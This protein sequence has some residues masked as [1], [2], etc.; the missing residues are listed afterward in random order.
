[1]KIKFLLVAFFT[2]IL[3]WCV[4][5]DTSFSISLMDKFDKKEEWTQEN[6]IYIEESE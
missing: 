4:Y 1:M 3:V 5:I 2:V 6:P